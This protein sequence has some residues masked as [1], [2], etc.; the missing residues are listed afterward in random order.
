MAEK[1]GVKMYIDLV[2]YND[3]L[4]DKFAM[5]LNTR[6]RKFAKKFVAVDSRDLQD[7]IRTEGLGKSNYQTVAG[8]VMGTDRPSKYRKNKKARLIAYALAQE[9]GRPDLTNYT[10]TSY[11][12]PAAQQ[13]VESGVLSEVLAEAEDAALRGSQSGK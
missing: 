12:R 4:T 2:K 9:F 5:I 3:I 8:G 13:A 7:S 10:F 6:V 1:A 11:M